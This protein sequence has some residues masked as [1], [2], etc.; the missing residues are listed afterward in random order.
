MARRFLGMILMLATFVGSA[1]CEPVS[2]TREGVSRCECVPGDADEAAVADLR[3]CFLTMTGAEL[4]LVEAPTGE[5][6]IVIRLGAE[7]LTEKEQET[8]RGLD[9]AEE[10]FLLSVR[11]DEIRIG[12]L[13]EAG[14]TNGIYEL[15]RELGCRWYYPGESGAVIPRN[16]EAAVESGDR[17]VTPSFALRRFWMVWG[18]EGPNFPDGTAKAMNDWARRN[19]RSGSL[20]FGG[21][22]YYRIV[23]PAKYGETHPEYF[24]LL[25]KKRFF[26][27]KSK[28]GWQICTSNEDV[29]QL[30]IEY[31]RDF[32][33][34]GRR[35]VSVSPNDSGG[36]CQCEACENQ[37]S[38]TDRVVIL[39][40]RVA[41]ALAE[42]YP[43]RLVGFYGY[44]EALPPPSVPVHENV[45]VYLCR[46]ESRLHNLT[47]DW[48]ESMFSPANARWREEVFDGWTA[49]AK[50]LA[51]RD[52]WGLTIWH[53]A[54]YDYAEIFD[55]DFEELHRL[56]FIGVNAEMLNG[57]ASS[58]FAPY[59]GAVKLWDV[60]ADLVAERER[61]YR[62][63]FG[64]A[65]GDVL[66][67]MTRLQKAQMRKEPLTDADL[68]FCTA[69]LAAAKAKAENEEVRKRLDWLSGYFDYVS[70]LVRYRRE[71]EADPLARDLRNRFGLGAGTALK[72]ALDANADSSAFSAR[73]L[74]AYAFADVGGDARAVDLA[75]VRGASPIRHTP[76]ATQYRKTHYFFVWVGSAGRLAF[77]VTHVPVGSD[78][79]GCRL[80]VADAQGK[81]VRSSE[82]ARG[83][84]QAVSLRNLPE[85]LYGVAVD[86]GNGAFKIN[87]RNRYVVLEAREAHP[88]CTSLSPR[89]FLVPPGTKAFTVHVDAPGGTEVVDVTLIDPAG[90]V[91]LEKKGFFGKE[92]FRVKVAPGTHGVWRLDA[93]ASEDA[94]IAL[95]GVP[96]YL[97]TEPGRL[98][99]PARK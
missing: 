86:P 7:V 51:L 11:P 38:I 18:G 77:D 23:P 25:G 39:A 22:S 35:I 64:E 78:P 49:K 92:D 34:R 71:A 41:E 93:T 15:L 88:F 33:A 53:E 91:V 73:V 69:R 59:L 30:A 74:R 2:L 32:L 29:V 10:G 82:M 90:K 37:G 57:W 56:G 98:L 9:N 40:N 48:F 79:A 72:E 17:Y 84:T 13:T 70:A 21:H 6:P 16:P 81:V 94:K 97:A 80:A 14:T 58:G 68:G 87:F 12:G 60:N 1:G 52:Y 76:D 36:F 85:G 50:H 8:L 26:L 43:D 67:A 19:R 65:A 95:S 63:L 66:A 89:H 61:M 54:P 99:A 96:P 46:N 27:P 42:E 4:P 83:A 47:F 45:V 5:R 44:M 62:D 55:R 75:P 3:D 24:G 28:H 31:A 20:G